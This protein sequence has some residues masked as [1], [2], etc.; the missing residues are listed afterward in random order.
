MN[1]F[2]ENYLILYFIIISAVGNRSLLTNMNSIVSGTSPVPG[3]T[4][5]DYFVPYCDASNFSDDDGQLHFCTH[6]IEI[7]L[8]EVV[9]FVLH[10]LGGE[11]FLM[12]CTC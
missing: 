2:L 3:L 11:L 9:D 8:N 5:K 4:Q 1:N 6:R 12:F 7:K 10:D